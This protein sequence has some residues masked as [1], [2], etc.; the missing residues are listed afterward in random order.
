M[1]DFQTISD[2]EAVAIAAHRGASW[3][4]ALATVDSSSPVE[5]AAAMARGTRSLVMRGLAQPAEGRLAL[6]EPLEALA[7][8]VSSGRPLHV[9][10]A[11][12]GSPGSAVGGVVYV[13]P[14]TADGQYPVDI[15]HGYGIHDLSVLARDDVLK[16]LSSMVTSAFT[17]GASA[18]PE[19]NEPQRRVVYLSRLPEP[20]EEAVEV[21]RN[22]VSR[23]RFGATAGGDTSFTPDD[24]TAAL[25]MAFLGDLLPS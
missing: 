1:S 2:D 4:A 5:L 17:G 9:Y 11:A 16:V 18:T 7:R 24:S 15:V 14:P 19:D 12:A 3:P 8:A 22:R 21:S 10:P 23:G 13:Y 25:D 20:G 6:D